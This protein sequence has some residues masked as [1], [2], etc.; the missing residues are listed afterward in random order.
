MNATPTYNMV[1]AYKLGAILLYYIESQCDYAGLVST[2]TIHEC[3][4]T[5]FDNDACIYTNRGEVTIKIYILQAASFLQ[6]FGFLRFA[7]MYLK[8]CEMELSLVK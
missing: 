8:I 3:P 7:R 4:S 5:P 2:Y 6:Q 1:H